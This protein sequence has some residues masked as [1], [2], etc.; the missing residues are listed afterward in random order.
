MV[1]PERFGHFGGRYVPELLIPPLQELE[2]AYDSIG[3]AEDFRAELTAILKNY[4]GRPTTLTEVKNFAK[5]IG[6]IRVFLKREDLLHTG[7][8]KIN[9]S[10]GQCLLAKKWVKRAL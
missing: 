8:H 4:I 7:A 9:N 6:D 1:R 10:L 2:R 5:A 3:K